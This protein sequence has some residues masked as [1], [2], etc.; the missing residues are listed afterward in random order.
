VTTSAATE[1]AR[2]NEDNPVGTLV[3]YWRGVRE[4]FEPSSVGRIRQPAEL[5]TGMPIGWIDTCSGYVALTHIQVVA[6][7]EEREAEVFGARKAHEQTAARLR[8]I[9]DTV[10]HAALD[11]YDLGMS[12]AIAEHQALLARIEAAYAEVTP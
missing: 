4:G 10:I 2:W 1:V 3:R 5:R 9:R 8:D 6:A 12:A 11:R 7:G